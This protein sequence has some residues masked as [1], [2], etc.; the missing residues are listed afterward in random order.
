MA[1]THH[2]PYDAIRVIAALVKD[3]VIISNI[4]VPSKE[5]FAVNDRDLNFYMLGA[6]PRH[7]QSGW[8][9]QS[10][11][12]KD[13][14]SCLTVTGACSGH[15]FSRDWSG[16]TQEPHDRCARQ[17]G[18]GSTGNQP[19]PGPETADLRLMAMGAGF[20]HTWTAHNPDELEK[21]FQRSGDLG[22][23]FI[24]VRLLPGNASVPN[25]PLSPEQIR[26]RFMA[27]IP[28]SRHHQ[29]TGMK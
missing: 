13:G 12:Q 1:C 3:E 8:A 24:H 23:C 10:Y 18:I 26:D 21:A 5:L 20:H 7:Q 6:A 4:G 27:A 19:R 2:D 25:I 28:Q 22:P 17:R 9:A 29:R 16:S 14:S 15:P 11:G